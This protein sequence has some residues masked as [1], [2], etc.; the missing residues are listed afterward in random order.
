M[1]A[2]T[3]GVKHDVKCNGCGTEFIFGIRYKCVKCP[4]FN[5]C[6]TCETQ[7]QHDHNMIKMK[8]IEEI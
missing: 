2:K 8:K 7:I 5:L 1:P 3:E 4:V 6:E